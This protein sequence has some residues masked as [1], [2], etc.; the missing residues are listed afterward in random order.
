MNLNKLETKTMTKA[1][2]LKYPFLILFINVMFSSIASAESFYRID[3]LG[4]HASVN[5]KIK[6]L[7]YSW[8]TGRFKKFAGTFHYDEKDPSKSKISMTVKTRSFD[9][10]HAIRDNH[11][12]GAK[13]LNV[14]KY[15]TARFVSTSFK[16]ISKKKARLTGKLTLHSVTKDISTEITHI[17][18]GKDPWGGYRQGFETHFKIRLKDY[19]IKHNLGAASEELELSIYLEG[20]QESLEDGEVKN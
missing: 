7:G 6:H 1:K 19:G 14:K 2:I 11:I 9:S 4:G 18:G 5:F 12:R 13:Y 8:L 10:D 16:P 15:P 3:T 17:G 20:V